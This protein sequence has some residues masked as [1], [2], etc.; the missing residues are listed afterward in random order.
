MESRSYATLR[1][2]WLTVVSF[3]LVL[4]SAST[5]ADPVKVWVQPSGDSFASAYA[6]VGEPRTYFGRT[7]GGSG[8]Y[9]YKWDF[10]DGATTGPGFMGVGV[11]RYIGIDGK[12]FATSGTH[13][14]R[15]TVRD[16]ADTS[17]TATAQIDLQVVSS[18]DLG[19]QKNSAIDRGLRNMYLNENAGS[20]SSYWN[21]EGRPIAATGIALV[22][23]ENQGHNLQSADSDIYKKSVQQ[24][25]QYLLDNAQ[26]LDV[27]DQRCIGNPETA[28]TGDTLIDGKGVRFG[29]DDLYAASM[30][31]LAL[32]NSADK[33]FAQA[34]MASTGSP[35]NGMSLY[36]IAI[37]AKDW[38]AWAQGD[39]SSSSSSSAY[40]DNSAGGGAY[41]VFTVDYSGPGVTSIQGYGYNYS[42]PMPGGSL[43][44]FNIDWGD[45]NSSTNTNVDA[46]GYAT[47]YNEPLLGYTDAGGTHTYTT[48]GNHTIHFSF[49]GADGV[50]TTD[51]CGVT[52]TTSGAGSACGA[53]DAPNAA[54]RYGSNY[55]SSDNSVT[56][57]PVLALN[58]AKNRWDIDTNQGV[59]D[60]LGYW[61][62]YSQCSNGAFGYAS[63]DSSG[64]C[65]FPKSAG[66]L[67]SLKYQGK[68]LAD[69]AV[70]NDLAFLG[71]NWT[72]S[73]YD[74]NFANHYSMYAFYKGMKTWGITDLGATTATGQGWQTQYDQDL[75]TRQN[76]DGSW[77]DQGGWMDQNIA[78]YAAVAI[79]APD[80]ASLPPVA[81]AGAPYPTINANQSL[82]LNGANSFHKDPSKHIVLWQWDFDSS[83][84]LWWD[85]KPSPTAGEGAVGVTPTLPGYP[86]V[87]HAQAYTV[88]LRVTDD[89][90]PTPAHASDTATVNVAS[91]NVAPV[92][93]A[94][95]PWS[96]LPNTPITFDASASYDPNACTTAGNPS[97]LGDH[98][99]SY[100]WDLNGD[101]IFNNADG[102]DGT[103]VV[104]GDWKIV[105]K[106]FANPGSLPAKLR[107][108]DSFGLQAT[109]TASNI[110]IV[111]IALVYGQDYRYCYA[112][113]LDRFRTRK[114]IQV[115]F[116]N[117]GTG[118]AE[119]VVMTL[120]NAPSNL[121]IQH[122][123]VANL[124]NLWPITD[125]TP[126]EPSAKVTACNAA[127]TTAD[128]EV[129]ADTRIP[130]SGGWL[131]KADF[132]FGG[133]HYTV[134][135]I[136]PLTP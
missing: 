118:E 22:A 1:A 131:W 56:Q 125:T 80:V 72:T 4:F 15:L 107:V 84:G 100:E 77:N 114:G 41:G 8:S 68:P 124:G 52:I 66:A 2:G 59:K 136:P 26:L 85:T 48:D 16:T 33:A 51:M 119:N 40:C 31:V 28:A 108:T 27:S 74:Y 70:Q 50:T 81:N 99:V 104:A 29:S 25:I 55:G 88:T 6:L 38:L 122:G 102:S 62:D 45:G 97:C 121:T 120:T 69:I 64:W 5:W 30:A 54:W 42:N 36:N 19:R 35:V 89:A 90:T 14:A 11:P 49:T 44:A 96:G 132:D 47:N 18:D 116:G 92:P 98:I 57:W 91:G 43:G 60:M 117:Q 63:G 82:A 24:G 67:I 129:V 123:G 34:T 87:G 113:K 112:V 105:K 23:F 78:T 128:I 37:Q 95:G 73:G 109:S 126:G 79:L 7:E 111:S 75:V 71:N 130:A 76:A 83:D 53:A 110:N 135:N 86:D 94:N 21:G 61:L 115:L 46:Y 20:G 101:G 17:N 65:N 32:V 93:V 106:S 13:W 3:L 103:P 134:N 58:E 10:S 39:G 9:E 133:L 12:S 127:A